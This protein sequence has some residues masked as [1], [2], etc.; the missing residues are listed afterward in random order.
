M[1]KPRIDHLPATA[2][3]AAM[4]RREI[5]ILPDKRLRQVSDPVKKIDASVRKLVSDMFETMYDAPGIGL[6][7]IQVGALFL[8]VSQYFAPESAAE[9]LSRMRC[10]VF[11]L[12]MIPLIFG[13]SPARR[14][15]IC[16]LQ[17]IACLVRLEARWRRS[18]AQVL[19]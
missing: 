19:F 12:K 5:L 7:A 17:L 15:Q 6:A 9:R 11:A 10:V 14:Q 1:Q 8:L 13:S 4:A 18:S 3:I 2:Y 16:L